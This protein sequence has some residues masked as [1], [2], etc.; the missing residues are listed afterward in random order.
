MDKTIEIV[1]VALVALMV[2]TILLFLVQDRSSNFGE[3]LGNQQDGA[4]GDLWEAQGK[5]LNAN[6]CE[7]WTKTEC[8]EASQ[9]SNPQVCTD[10]DSRV[11]CEAESNCEWKSSR[12]GDSYC[13][14]K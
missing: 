8:L 4:Q 13:G 7:D 6:Q 9:D 1:V 10:I 3:F 14:S 12:R 5:C 2:A 11:A